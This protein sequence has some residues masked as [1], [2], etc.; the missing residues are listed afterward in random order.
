[1]KA[2]HYIAS[3]NFL[4]PILSKTS[5]QHFRSHLT[6]W[7]LLVAGIILTAT[8]YGIYRSAQIHLLEKF[9]YQQ[10]LLANTVATFINGNKH[11]TFNS[12]KSMESQSYRYY[13][14]SF[15]NIMKSDNFSSFIYTVNLDI[16]KRKI[17][18]GIIPK[19]HEQAQ[20]NILLSGDDLTFDNDFVEQLFNFYQSSSINNSRQSQTIHVQ[21]TH[22]SLS[23][24][25]NNNNKPCGLLVVEVS[26]KRI[27]QLKNELFKSMLLTI[28]LLIFALL[29][30]TLF[31]AKKITKPLDLLTDAIEH[32]I[33]N[34]FNFNLTLS[35][36]DGFT[37]LA[38]QFNLMILKLRVSRHDLVLL[39][40]SYSR[41]VPHQVLK[42]I[43]PLGVKSTSLG[44]CVEKE[45]TILFCDIRNFTRLSE[46]IS[47]SENFNFL[48]KYLNIVVPVI[49]QYGGTVDKFMGDGIM[50]LFPNSADHAIDAAVGMM[51]EL[52]KYNKKLKRR[53]LLP[54]EIGIGLH[55]GKMMLGTVGTSARMDVTVISD[56]VNAAARIES[57]T[58]TFHSPIL[59]SEELRMRLK[60]FD[61]NN[62]RFIATCAVKGKVQPMTLYEVFS[63][64]S[65]S[66]RHE[67][68]NNQ[69]L[70]IKAWRLYKEGNT[71]QALSIYQKLMQKSPSDKA[72]LALFE[73]VQNG[74]L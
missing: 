13:N 38:K 74:R 39:N 1:M 32:L 50:A 49:N 33:K 59:I 37:H 58:K 71:E 28:A 4:G 12:Y 64:D 48:N 65:I 5:N 10:Q 40:K 21:Q 2:L 41:F 60:I 18:Y 9:N 56:T 6:F 63:Q 22:Y 57:L 16:K 25:T 23:L 11:K 45:M 47:P 15:I 73:A 3:Y 17:T 46:L 52:D 54:I 66:I 53:N 42:M 68:L 67:K 43:S 61:K 35:N 29:S 14:T 55:T 36:F 62:L 72:Q 20:E 8:G 27:F 70:M 24:I 31:F 26:G 7:F 30:L 69:P 34:D 44:D 19:L 51:A